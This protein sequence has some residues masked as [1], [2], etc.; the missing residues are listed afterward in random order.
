MWQKRMNQY[1]P[2]EIIPNIFEIE[3][4]QF[5][6]IQLTLLLNTS[7]EKDW[8]IF[9]LKRDLLFPNVS[10]KHIK[11]ELQYSCKS[12]QQMFRPAFGCC[13][14]PKAGRNTQHIN[15]FLFR[16][17]LYLYVLIGIWTGDLRH[18]TTWICNMDALDHGHF[19]KT[20]SVNNVHDSL[21]I[22]WFI[23]KHWSKLNDRTRPVPPPPPKRPWGQN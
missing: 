5:N 20:A 8:F 17:N 7:L 6:T 13:K 3:E 10:L 21:K 23:V 18:D 2:R 12:I 1:L 14:Q 4:Q 16:I 11:K 15:S 22:C 9:S 19:P